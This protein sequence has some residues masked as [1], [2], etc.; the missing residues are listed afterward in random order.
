MFMIAPKHQIINMGFLPSGSNCLNIFF[1]TQTFVQIMFWIW[2]YLFYFCKKNFE[3]EDQWY[4]NT[5]MT[6]FVISLVTRIFIISVRYATTA[7]KDYVEQAKRLLTREE[8]E[9]VLLAAAWVNIGPETIWREIETSIVRM[10]I[11]KSHFRI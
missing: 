11:I 9:S 10:N 1:F 5:L 6:I 4:F 2:C 7:L 3:E 8:Y